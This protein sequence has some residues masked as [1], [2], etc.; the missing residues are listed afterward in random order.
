MKVELLCLNTVNKPS[1]ISK[2]VTEIRI[3]QPY[4]G[5][6][7]IAGHTQ[8]RRTTRVATIHNKAKETIRGPPH[9]SARLPKVC[10]SGHTVGGSCT[11]PMY[12]R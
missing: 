11:I 5:I 4:K 2:G 6:N 7:L 1:L 3:S 8:A 9:P 10:L 12:T